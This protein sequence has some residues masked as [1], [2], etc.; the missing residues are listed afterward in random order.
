MWDELLIDA[1]TA[2]R[3]VLGAVFLLAAA[4][5]VTRRGQTY[6]FIGA[7][8]V[9]DAVVPASYVLT[10][11]VEA[12][13][14][15]LF[16]VGATKLAALAGS[17]LFAV[18]LGVLVR[19]RDTKQ[20]CACLGNSDKEAPLIRRALPRIAG[21]VACLALLLMP[22]DLA[23][24]PSAMS[25]LFAAGP[26]MWIVR[27]RKAR[28]SAT[29][30]PA[31]KVDTTG[32]PK[33]SS[34]T[35]GL[36]A[37]ELVDRRSALT[38]GA[39][40]AAAGLVMP[41]AK[42]GNLLGF[43]CCWPECSANEYCYSSATGQCSCMPD[44]VQRVQQLVDQVYQPDPPPPCDCQCQYEEPNCQEECQEGDDCIQTTCSVY[45]EK[46]GAEC[47]LEFILYLECI[48]SC[49]DAFDECHAECLRL[50]YQCCA[51]QPGGCARGTN[52]RAL[53]TLNKAHRLGKTDGRWAERAWLTNAIYRESSVVTA[54]STMALSPH[55]SALSRK[56]QR[57]VRATLAKRSEGLLSSVDTYR[58][59]VTDKF[60]LAGVSRAERLGTEALR[61]SRASSS[62]RRALANEP[63]DAGVL[64]VKPRPKRSTSAIRSKSD[65][66]GQLRAAVDRSENLL[67]FAALVEISERAT[68]V[69]LLKE[70][71]RDLREVLRRS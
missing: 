6:E 54:F 55:F 7:L 18:F 49:A 45:C 70:W 10:I 64:E 47:T 11:V 24:S 1:A 66:D 21:L 8:G 25:Y 63:I 34:D 39:G 29:D 59:E 43:S 44:P 42:L 38:R 30:R 3:L 23:V 61:L 13:V 37:S 46:P 53:A 20:P 52:P 41:M 57:F 68:P 33:H 56:H 58:R 31:S 67:H 65:L 62:E 26:I 4:F 32:P 35:S 17:V 51:S 19:V 40:L 36:G 5:K 48:A 9:P 12:S 60:T 69:I 28:T 14:G 16:L 22:L 2:V 15:A 50:Y 71:Q 27:P